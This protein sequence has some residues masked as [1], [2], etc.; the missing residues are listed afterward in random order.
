VL[1][2]PVE[3]LTVMFPGQP[4]ITGFVSSTTVTVKLQVLLLP[5][6]SVAFTVTVVVPTEIVRGDVISV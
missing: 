5:A 2:L 6:P 4:L 1:E 3:L